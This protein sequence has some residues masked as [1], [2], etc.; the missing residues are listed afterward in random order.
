MANTVVWSKR[1][2]KRKPEISGYVIEEYL[3]QQLSN[4]LLSLTYMLKS[5][6]QDT[7]KW[8]KGINYTSLLKKIKNDKMQNLEGL[9][10]SSSIGLG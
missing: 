4:F 10:T 1:G 2:R 7:D 5:L 6:S 9:Y 8:Y 3:C